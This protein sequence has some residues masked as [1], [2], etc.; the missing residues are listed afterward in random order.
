MPP[1]NTLVVSPLRAGGATAPIDKGA[2][3][4]AN[5]GLKYSNLMMTSKNEGGVS[6]ATTVGNKTQNSMR[7]AENNH[8]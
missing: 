4:T 5:L 7:G 2:Q 1:D 6:T 3:G 8:M